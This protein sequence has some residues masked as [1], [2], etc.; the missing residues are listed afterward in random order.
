MSARQPRNAENKP[1]RKKLR[2]SKETLKDLTQAKGTAGRV[3]GG[4]A[5]CCEN[6]STS[7]GTWG[8]GCSF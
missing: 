3:K 8:G 7:H 6:G 4:A 5:A 2:L 1:A